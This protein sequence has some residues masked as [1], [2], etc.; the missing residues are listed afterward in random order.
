MPSNP[1]DGSGPLDVDAAFAEIVAHWG[2]PDAGGTPGAP[3][4]RTD[5]PA[6]APRPGTPA[7]TDATPLPD[8]ARTV[9]PARPLPPAPR[10]DVPAVPPRRDDV[11]EDMALAGLDDRFVP[12]EPQ[13]LPR[14][15]V[16]WAAWIAVIGAPLFLLVVALVWRDVPAL[17]TAATAVV[18]VAGFATLVVRLPS[19]RD[20]DSDDGAVV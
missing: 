5:A 8:A 10:E 4:G 18:F 9:R 3:E 2:D 11:D 7:G 16:G 17:V 19:S 12:P 6:P 1:D 15:L 20:D 13:P 14:D